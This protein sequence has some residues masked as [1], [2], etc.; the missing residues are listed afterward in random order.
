MTT[1]PLATCTICGL[2]FESRH[3]YGLCPLCFSRDTAREYDRLEAAIKHARRAKLP[4]SLTL[5]QWLSV[6]SD[7]NANCAY[8]LVRPFSH[9]EMVDLHSGLTRENVV[10]ICLSCQVHK[11]SSFDIA[12]RRVAAYLN[13][14]TSFRVEQDEEGNVRVLAE[15]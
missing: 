2:T 3:S 14:D 1:L 9:I 15:A 13:G 10:P 8:C 11:R 7:F 6:V 4:V 12:K 5:T